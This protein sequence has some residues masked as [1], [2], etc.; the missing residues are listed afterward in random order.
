LPVDRIIR[1]INVL[2]F[3]EYDKLEWEEDYIYFS[4]YKHTNIFVRRAGLE[5]KKMSLIPPIKM[6]DKAC[7]CRVP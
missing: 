4:R 3:D 2:T 1:K 6:W 5:V 7:I